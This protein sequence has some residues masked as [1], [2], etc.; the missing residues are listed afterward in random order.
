MHRFDKNHCLNNWDDWNTSELLK[1]T[2]AWFE[3]L[4]TRGHLLSMYW[5]YITLTTLTPC[6]S[7]SVVYA[8][9]RVSLQGFHGGH[10]CYYCSSFPQCLGLSCCS[11]LSS[12]LLLAFVAVGFTMRELTGCLHLF[13]V[14]LKLRLAFPVACNYGEKLS[15]T[16]IGCAPSE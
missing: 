11:F 10:E 3:L 7:P 12:V 4:R 13:V 6:H 5:R 14:Y 9:L 1:S 8:S 15:I 16:S 2:H